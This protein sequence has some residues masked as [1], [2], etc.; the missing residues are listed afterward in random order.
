[1]GPMT[2][3]LSFDVFFTH[4]FNISFEGACSPRNGITDTNTMFIIPFVARNTILIDFLQLVHLVDSVSQYSL[5]AYIFID[6][7]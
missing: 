1:M 4:L 3:F 7:F 6:K 5:I 2:S